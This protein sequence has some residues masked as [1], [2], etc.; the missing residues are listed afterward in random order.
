[1]NISGVLESELQ[2]FY[3]I[4]NAVSYGSFNDLFIEFS[5]IIEH[6]LLQPLIGWSF[7]FADDAVFG[8]ISYYIYIIS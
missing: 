8:Y 4:R 2:F 1:M 7:T 6:G 3:N 5:D